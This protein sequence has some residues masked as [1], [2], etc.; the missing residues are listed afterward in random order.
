MFEFG[1]GDLWSLGKLHRCKGVH[2]VGSGHMKTV[3]PTVLKCY[4]RHHAL[5][6]LP[7]FQRRDSWN[8]IALV[9]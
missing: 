5:G 4:F 3:I 9:T 1:D 2:S 6:L 7:K 8:G